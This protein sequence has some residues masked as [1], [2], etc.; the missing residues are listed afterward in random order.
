MDSL[1]TEQNNHHKTKIIKS[2]QKQ[3][4]LIYYLIIQIDVQGKHT[5]TRPS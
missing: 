1:P 3:H 2:S 5:H 4:Q